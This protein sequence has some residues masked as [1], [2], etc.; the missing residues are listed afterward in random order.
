MPIRT[1]RIPEVAF[2]FAQKDL[3][4][5]ADPTVS[6]VVALAALFHIGGFEL[7][8]SV[9]WERS[10]FKILGI[11]AVNFGGVEAEDF[12]LVFFGDFCVA[13]FLAKFIGDLEALHGVND[14]LGR[15]PPEAIGSPNDVVGAVGLN[16]LSNQ[17]LAQKRMNNGGQ[18]K[19]RADF[20][21]D[22]VD[23]GVPLFDF[24]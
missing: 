7:G 21:V 10:E 17:M 16:V 4:L 19:G 1:G 6:G 15:S 12:C 18:A 5:G 11:D 24:H 3:R 22:V 20:A 23:F 8:E 9:F 2:F 13:K 14:P